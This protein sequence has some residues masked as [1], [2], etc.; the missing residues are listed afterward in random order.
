MGKR[1]IGLLAILLLLSIVLTGCNEWMNYI[2]TDAGLMR[3]GR[4]LLREKYDEEF[5]IYD[6]WNEGQ[7]SFFAVCSPKNNP[8]VV[9]EAKIRKDG[10]KIWRDEYVQG[11]VGV[12]IKKKLLP[13]IQEISD[14]CVVRPMLFYH[15][16]EFENVQT[17]T[18]EEYKET[19]GEIDCYYVIMIN[20]EQLKTNNYEEEYEIFKN[21]SSTKWEKDF[22][23]AL[24]FVDA[25]TIGVTKEY[26][27]THCDIT[28]KFED[29][30]KNIKLIGLGYKDASINITLEE[31]E[32]M[33]AEVECRTGM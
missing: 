7:K 16:G 6:V 30:E 11:I 9:F 19:I 4:R 17:V 29:I 14:S 1:K 32:A 27:E 5:V 18:I 20:K 10:S 28:G 22:A 33:R 15:E 31:Y 3:R 21:I 8:E 23:I 2:H 12:E 26:F 13:E 24:Y 25:E